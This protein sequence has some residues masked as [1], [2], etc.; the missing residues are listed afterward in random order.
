MV[1][2]EAIVIGS[3]VAGMASA[4]RL[5]IKG[6]SVSVFE[7]NEYPG[8]KLSAIEKDGYRFDAGPSLFTKPHYLHDLFRDAGERLEEYLMYASVPLSCRYFFENGKKVNAWTDKD[9]YEEELYTQLGEPKGNLKNYLQKK[10][11]RAH[12]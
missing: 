8:G 2:R 1:K 4:I 3:G 11:G 7:K 10:I 12:V 9:S 6:F 5:A